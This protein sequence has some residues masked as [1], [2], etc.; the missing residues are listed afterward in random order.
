MTK[1]PRD[2]I[3]TSLT[4]IECHMYKCFLKN[5][6]QQSDLSVSDN[7]EGISDSLNCQDCL[8]RL[9]LPVLKEP[10]YGRHNTL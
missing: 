3:Q 4:A 6:L 8:N 7:L 2:K 9:I 5:N 1:T 10:Q